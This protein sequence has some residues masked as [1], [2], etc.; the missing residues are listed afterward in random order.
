[1]AT[2]IG[3]H[4]AL[5]VHPLFVSLLLEWVENYVMAFEYLLLNPIAGINDCF[6]A[7]LNLDKVAGVSA[8][9][10]IL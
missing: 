9:R 5:P 7:K 6:V 3:E 4:T 2:Q 1:M 8:L 10:S